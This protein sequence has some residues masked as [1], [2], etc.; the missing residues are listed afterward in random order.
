SAYAVFAGALVYLALR[1]PFEPRLL[2]A[3]AACML[4]AGLVAFLLSAAQLVPTLELMRHAAR[5]PLSLADTIPGEPTRA[6]ALAVATGRGPAIVVILAALGDRRRWPVVVPGLVVLVLC[7]LVGLGTPLYTH[8]FYHLP[9]VAR[10]RVVNRT[11]IV[12]AAI[13]AVLGAIGLDVLR[14]T[15]S[16]SVGRRLAAAAC[17]LALALAWI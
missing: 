11:I 16:R 3:A 8:G 4:L 13:A 7:L 9:G 6:F 5:G 15:A 2:V 10:F 1:R 17:M 12:G 14:T